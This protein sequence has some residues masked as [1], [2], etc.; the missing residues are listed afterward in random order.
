MD[1]GFE[2]RIA[3]LLTFAH[4]ARVLLLR[5]RPTKLDIDIALGC[6]PFEV[7]AVSRRRMKT[8]AGV[9]IP[10]PTPED[11]IIMKAVAHRDQDFLDIDG[12]IA[13]QKKLDVP[14]IRRWVRSF[15]DALEIPELYDDL[16]KRLPAP[17]QPKPKKKRP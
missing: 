17:A 3:D 7:E 10:L 6:L 4:Q 13:A 8:L 16:N 15:A 1:F 9:K 12:V 5:H 11:L 2:A 14:R